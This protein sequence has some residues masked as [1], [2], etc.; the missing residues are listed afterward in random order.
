MKEKRLA[1]P[2]IDRGRNKDT[3]EHGHAAVDMLNK[4][5]RPTRGLCSRGRPKGQCIHQGYPE[6]VQEKTRA[7]LI[8]TS[9][10]PET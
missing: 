6:C 10:G 2:G 7:S 1:S 3:E 4:A 9:P 5:R 8:A